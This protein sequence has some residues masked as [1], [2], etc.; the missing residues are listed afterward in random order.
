MAL[1][2]N[3]G[4][5]VLVQFL[6]GQNHLSYHLNR[7]LDLQS[8]DVGLSTLS[9][10]VNFFNLLVVVTFFFNV[11]LDFFRLGE[12]DYRAHLNL[13]YYLVLCG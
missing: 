12:I 11:S 10:E 2:E 9:K 8:Q 7:L 3:V 6:R 5:C 4:N 13:V 1:H